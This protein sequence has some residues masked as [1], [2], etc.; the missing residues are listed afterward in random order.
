L[1]HGT[2]SFDTFQLALA[3]LVRIID[4]R[5]GVKLRQYRHEFSSFQDNASMDH[6]YYDGLSSSDPPSAP[7]APPSAPSSAPSS[8]SSA[9]SASVHGGDGKERGRMD[10]TRSHTSLSVSNMAKQK[11]QQQQQKKQ[12]KQEQQEQQQKKGSKRAEDNK[13]DNKNTGTNTGTNEVVKVA[14]MAPSE[15]DDYL[16]RRSVAAV[17]SGGAMTYVHM[18]DHHKGKNVLCWLFVLFSNFN[19]SIHGGLIFFLKPE[20]KRPFW[21]YPKRWRW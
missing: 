6:K 3:R 9:S 1:D 18:N 15:I 7:S 16:L 11:Q 4:S 13:E 2:L 12:Q 21:I 8:P 5:A 19:T 17:D 20:T 14:D 10:R